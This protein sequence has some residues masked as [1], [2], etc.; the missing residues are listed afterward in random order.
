[1]ELFAL[2]AHQDFIALY[3]T[4]NATAL[5]QQELT[6]MEEYVLH[7]HQIVTH[8]QVEPFARLA[9][10]AMGFTQII[11][12]ITLVQ[13]ELT[14]ME[15]YALHAHQIVTHA[16][17]EPFARLAQQGMDSMMMISAITLVPL[18]PT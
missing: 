10:Q 16:Q 6:Y 1:M 13:Q 12:A 9:P 7:A 8:A 11:F 18:R 3:S 17:V 14:Y 15:E 5:V 2:H 4:T